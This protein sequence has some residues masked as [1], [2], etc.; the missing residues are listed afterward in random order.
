MRTS[1]LRTDAFMLPKVSDRPRTVD[2]SCGVFASAA[3]APAA[4]NAVAIAVAV[5]VAVAVVVVVVAVV[6]VNRQEVNTPME[7]RVLYAN[8]FLDI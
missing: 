6:V 7:T 8:S 4:V 2:V 5:A 3:A 1:G